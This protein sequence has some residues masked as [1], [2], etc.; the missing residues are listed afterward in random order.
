M[1]AFGCRRNAPSAPAGLRGAAGT[2][3]PQTSRAARIVSISPDATEILYAIGAGDR[4]AGVCTFCNYPDTVRDLPRVGGYIDPNLERLLSLRPDLVIVRG[5]IESVEMLCRANGIE[6]YK[7]PTES[8]ADM[9]RTITDLGRLTG[10]AAAADGLIASIRRELDAVRQRVAHRPRPRVLIT[11]SRTP[12][13]LEGIYTAAKGSFLD[14]LI[15]IAGGQNIFG[16]QDVR[17]PVVSTEAILVRQPEVI[18]EAMPETDITDELIEKVRRQWAELGPLPAVRSNRIHVLR[19]SYT[20]RPSPRVTQTAAHWAKLLHPSE[21]PTPVGGDVETPDRVRNSTRPSEHSTPVGG[22]IA[23]PTTLEM[24]A[25]P[26]PAGRGSEP[27][28]EDDR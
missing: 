6:I 27:R 18:L 20:T 26:R 8:L 22:D 13:R 24:R 12:D 14:E 9:E 19:E 25:I 1:P 7:D 23:T 10:H 17:Y 21:P 15:E 3:A 4:L 16:D 28:P 11:I 5:T 2:A